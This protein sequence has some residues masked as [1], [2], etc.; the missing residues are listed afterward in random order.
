[1]IVCRPTGDYTLDDAQRWTLNADCVVQEK[2]DGFWCRATFTTAQCYG[3]SL[4]GLPLRMPFGSCEFTAEIDGELCGSEFVAFDCISY[5]GQSLTAWT[6]RDRLAL[7][8]SLTL[9]VWARMVRQWDSIKDALD[10][11][12][13]TDGEGIVLKHLGSPYDPARCGWTRAKRQL[14]SD[15]H[16]LSVDTHKQSAE[17]GEM[18]CGRMVSRGRIF[19]FNQPEAD[20]ASRSIG[21]V[22]EVCAMQRTKAGKL[23]HGRFLRFR[24]D[25]GAISGHSVHGQHNHSGSVEVQRRAH[26][27]R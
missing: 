10:F 9:P 20:M 12:R 19:G 7:L 11:I 8:A 5:G 27:L 18:V 21:S 3:V 26:A 14:T 1:M 24:F 25:K 17:V 15:F 22:V 13:D 2:A 6:L 16:L 4:S 23:R